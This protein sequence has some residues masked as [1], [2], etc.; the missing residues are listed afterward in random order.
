MMNNPERTT[1]QNGSER[2]CSRSSDLSFSGSEVSVFEAQRILSGDDGA[3]VLD[4]RSSGAFALGHI[5]GARQVSLDALETVIETLAGD[6]DSLV[7]VYCSIGVR[8]LPIVDALREKLEV[9]SQ[10]RKSS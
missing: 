7:L 4:A 8:T 9:G 3:V 6:C 1:L 5:R 2:F 10:S